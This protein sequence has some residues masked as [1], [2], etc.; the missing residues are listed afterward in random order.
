MGNY[1]N[2]KKLKE[3]GFSDNIIKK[4]LNLIKILDKK[5]PQTLKESS[6]EIQIVSSADGASHLTG[7]FHPIFLYENSQMNLNKLLEGNVGKIKSEWD[8]KIVLPEVKEIFKERK[9]L[10]LEINGRLPKRYFLNHK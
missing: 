7:P 6:I 9:D 8:N 4:S 2:R 5:D 1:K 3:I 10:L